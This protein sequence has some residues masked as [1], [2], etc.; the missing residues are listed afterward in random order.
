MYHGQLKNILL[1]SLR[2]IM[3]KLSYASDSSTSAWNTYLQQIE[4]VAPYLGELSPWVD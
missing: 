2:F 4:R 3:D 1:L